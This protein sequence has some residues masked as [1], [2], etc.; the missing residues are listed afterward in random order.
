MSHLHGARIVFVPVD[1]RFCTRDYFLML[2]QGAGLEVITPP[3]GELGQKK[4]PPDL[5]RLRKGVLDAVRS[6]D[7]VIASV[8]MLVHGGLIPSRVSLDSL[9]TLVERLSLFKAMKD[10]G[11]R[12]Y[13]SMSVTRAPFYDSSDEEPD[14]W[15]CYG[16]RLWA[17]SKEMARFR[18]RLCTREALAA[19]ARGI[20]EWVVEDFIARRKR[21]FALVSCVLDC[22]V[23]GA[24]DFLNL[25]LDDNTEGSL[26]L[27]EAEQHEKKVKRVG[28]EGKLSIHAGADESTLTLLSRTLCDFAGMTP[29]I[30]VDYSAPEMRR[31][32]PPFEG[33]PHEESIRSHLE[34]AGCVVAEGSGE[35]ALLFVHNPT[36]KRD[37]WHQKTARAPRA[38]YRRAV[39]RVAGYDGVAGIAGTRYVNGSDDRFVRDLLAQPLDWGRR[40]YA[41]WNTAGNTLGTVIPF[42]VVRLL[43]A[44]G[45][46]RAS[47]E[48]LSEIQGIFLLEHWAYMAHARGQLLRKAHRKGCKAWDLMPA[49]PWAVSFV[50]AALS[51]FIAPVNN[52]LGRTWKAARVSFPWHRAFEIRLELS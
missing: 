44:K 4:T 15:A 50:E 47:P 11:A 32:I 52:A 9:P 49:E 29:R 30:R 16:R 37:A 19:A 18:R 46:L 42:M 28:I 40:A 25:T 51:P 13:A 34:A 2:A 27:W 22:V 45:L 3:L 10:K 35:D 8:D 41:G 14:Y 36:D 24:I 38:L 48:K 21:N 26:S 31:F 12:V 7:T 17:L 23:D 5:P 1:E 33:S 39:A 6:S 43:Q 20:P